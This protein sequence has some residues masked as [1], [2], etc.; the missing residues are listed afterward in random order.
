MKRTPLVLIGSL[1]F[2]ENEG[3]FASPTVKIAEGSA[4]FAEDLAVALAKW[5]NVYEEN[6]RGGNVSDG[7]AVKRVHIVITEI[8]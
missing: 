1:S 3:G 2:E 8:D 7:V 6:N 4:M 5:A